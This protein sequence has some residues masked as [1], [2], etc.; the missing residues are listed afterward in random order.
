MNF[1]FKAEGYSENQMDSNDLEAYGK[2]RCYFWFY[3]KVKFWT[4][5]WR[6]FGPSNFGVF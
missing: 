3:T 1:F 2:K 5:F 4:G 6:L